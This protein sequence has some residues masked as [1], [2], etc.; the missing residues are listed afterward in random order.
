MTNTCKT[1]REFRSWLE[2]NI[3]FL[4]NVL[5]HGPPDGEDAIYVS[6]QVEEISAEAER[7]ACRLGFD[8][9]DVPALPTPRSALA[10]LG[11]LSAAMEQQDPAPTLDVKEVARLLGCTE[12]TIW[13]HEGKGL[14]PEARRIGGVVRWDRDELEIWLAN[15][16]REG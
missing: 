13:R 6:L 12:R 1:I 9:G 15:A 5:L 10:L 2:E 3:A 14:I 11:R 16:N 4:E 8:P 7:M